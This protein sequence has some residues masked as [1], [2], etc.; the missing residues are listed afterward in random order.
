[1]ISAFQEM[2]T[3]SDLGVLSEQLL[4]FATFLFKSILLYR[5]VL[6]RVNTLGK[7]IKSVYN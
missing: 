2:L 3:N 5:L 4:G 1:M 7:L 6:R